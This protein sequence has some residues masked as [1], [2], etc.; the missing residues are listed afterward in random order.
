[1]VADTDATVRVIGGADSSRAVNV[2]VLPRLVPVRGAGGVTPVERMDD[3]PGCGGLVRD[4]LMMPE[5][6][7]S[8]LPVT[9]VCEEKGWDYQIDQ[10]NTAS[11]FT[12]EGETM[13]QLES[14]GGM[15]VRPE[16]VTLPE[17]NQKL[18]QAAQRVQQP[19]VAGGAAVRG[20]WEH[21]WCWPS[22]SQR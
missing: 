17:P 5:C 10:G 18:A 2:R 13:A 11:R 19:E 15:S 12:A 3:L 1:M 20:S 16:E 8:L 21:M 7:Q 4:C 9:L 22:A 14:H 6:A